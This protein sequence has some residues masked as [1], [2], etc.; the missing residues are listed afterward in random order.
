M[1]KKTALETR[2]TTKLKPNLLA[3]SD[4]FYK[5]QI[6]RLWDFIISYQRMRYACFHIL[7]FSSKRGQAWFR[8]Y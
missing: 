6:L 4:D 8:F 2:A 7:V 3:F 1:N 5:F